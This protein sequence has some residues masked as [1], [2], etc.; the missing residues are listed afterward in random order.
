MSIRWRIWESIGEKKFLQ[1]VILNTWGLLKPIESLVEMKNVWEGGLV[2]KAW[3]L[4][5]VDFLMKS[6][7]QESIVDVHLPN[8]LIITQSKRENRSYGSWLHNRIESVMVVYRG[9]WW[10]P[11]ATSGPCNKQWW[12]LDCVWYKK[13]THLQPAIFWLGDKGIRS[14]VPLQMG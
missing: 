4:N 1:L 14:Q 10:K 13:K 3:R 8:E 11:L 5:H 6:F 9:C 2:Y 7:V 12:N